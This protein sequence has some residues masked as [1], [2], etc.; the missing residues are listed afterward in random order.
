[1]PDCF[2]FFFQR[3]FKKIC[4]AVTIGEF[5]LQD[6]IIS[7]GHCLVWHTAI[8]IHF[9]LIHCLF[10][11]LSENHF[12]CLEKVFMADLNFDFSWLRWTFFNVMKTYFGGYTCVLYIYIYIYNT[13]NPYIY[14]HTLLCYVWSQ[15]HCWASDTVRQYFVLFFLDWFALEVT[16]MTCMY[17]FLT[18]TPWWILYRPWPRHPCRSAT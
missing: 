2:V 3:Y 14:I 10:Q 17:W 12:A 1:M 16:I 9:F 18:F 4:F 6:F 11:L 7:L 13:Y 15:L 5:S 8:R